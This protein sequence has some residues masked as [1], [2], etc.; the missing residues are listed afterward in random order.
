VQTDVD[1]SVGPYR[2]EGFWLHNPVDQDNEPH[3]K[4]DACG[5]GN[6]GQANQWVSYDHWRETFFVGAKFDDPGNATQ[7]LFIATDDPPAIPP[8]LKPAGAPL[9]AAGMPLP[10]GGAL[11]PGGGTPLPAAKPLLQAPA[12]LDL[13]RKN[14]A[15]Y[16]LD[17]NAVTAKACA[18]SAGAPLLVR[19]LDQP[20]RSYALVPSEQAGAVVSYGQIDATDGNL[21]SIYVLDGGAKPYERDPASIAQSLAGTDVTLPGDAGTLKLIANEF[22]VDPQLVWKPCRES[23]WA[24]LPF[25]RIIAGSH[26]F[27]LRLDGRLFTDLTIDGRGG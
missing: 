5:T 25:W 7:F 2:I 22:T 24:H 9:H 26:V 16:G 15:R 20:G 13:F 27:Y 17:Q 11:L 8:P 19:R 10:G 12:M 18:C 6:H 23:K 3:S 21:E 14:L 4:A 1:P